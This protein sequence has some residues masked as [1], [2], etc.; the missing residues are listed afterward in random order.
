M[1]RLGTRHPE[2]PPAVR[3]LNDIT[4]KADVLEAAWSLASLCND[5]DGADDESATLRRL[6]EE[7]QTLRRSQGRKPLRLRCHRQETDAGRA[8]R[9]LL[10]A[11]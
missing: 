8:M 4:S 9:E 7:V 10:A 3:Y 5:G 1:A 2:V 11:Y 6:V